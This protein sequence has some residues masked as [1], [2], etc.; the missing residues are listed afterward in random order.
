M[1]REGRIVAR[2]P[3]SITQSPPPAPGTQ[4]PDARRMDRTGPHPNMPLPETRHTPVPETPCRR[5]VIPNKRSHQQ[6][7][8]IGLNTAIDIHGTGNIMVINTLGNVP[9][10]SCLSVTRPPMRTVVISDDE[11][12]SEPRNSLP[13]CVRP[14]QPI[15]ISSDEEDIEPMTSYFQASC[16]T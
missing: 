10:R 11:G 8:H 1:V 2:S 16:R 9:S 5:T 7:T 6:G 4:H 15:S 13:S 12:D 14:R 3:R